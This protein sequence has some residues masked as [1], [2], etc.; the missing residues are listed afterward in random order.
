MDLCFAP[1]RAKMRHARCPQVV[2]GIFRG[3]STYNT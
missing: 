2:S 3:K 1:G